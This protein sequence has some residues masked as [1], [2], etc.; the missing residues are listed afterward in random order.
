MKMKRMIITDKQ[1]KLL[2]SVMDQDKTQVAFNGNNANELGTNAQEKYNDALRGGLKPGAI[3]MNGKTNRNNATRGDEVQVAFQTDTPSI[4]QS[5]TDTVNN[6]VNNG[7][8][9][10]KLNIVGNPEDLTNTNV[11]EGKK[12]TKN[13]IEKARLSEMRKNG[14][15]V[16]KGYLFEAN[17]A[18]LEA[19]R[20]IR[21]LY[22]V[23]QP[24]T[25]HKYHD[26]AW[27]STNQVFDAIRNTPG[28]SDV[29]VSAGE[30]H[31]MFTNEIPWR[32]YDFDVELECGVLVGG[33]L[34]CHAAGTMED[35]FSSYDMTCMFY[36]K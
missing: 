16:T 8:D 5:V 22:K 18:T 28:V 4:K 19:N 12:Y 32:S 34:K 14:I 7:L 24:F 21:R 20:V 10:D 15:T 30:Y 23:T 9:I 1:A 26:S 25:I 29:S 36:K 11:A 33:Q 13:D 2:E 27:E 31:N 6:A 35:P 17:Q 3:T